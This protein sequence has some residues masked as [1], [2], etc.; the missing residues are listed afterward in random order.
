M[1]LPKTICMLPWISIETSPIGTT[2]PCCLAI[3]EIVDDQGNKFD[4][5][6][7]DL[8]TI[9]N[10]SYMQR[11]RKQ[12][13]QGEKP[14][15]CNRCWQEEDAGRVSKRIY[16]K[17]RLKELVDKVD[18]DN[19]I[20]KQLW[21]VD[22]KL[23]NICNLKCRICGSWS[24]SKWAQEEINYMT[25][26]TNKKDHLAYKFLQQGAWP[27]KTQTFWDNL[28]QLLPN[29]K[30]FEFTGG[31]PF[32]IQEH[33]DLLQYAVDQGYAKNIDIH[34]N[35][36]GTQW[37]DS[38]ELWSHF[39]R[40]E[41]AFSIDNIGERFE[42]ERYGARWNEVQE[43][44]SKFHQLRDRFPNKITTQVCMTIN[45]QNVYYLEDLCNWINTQTFNDHFFNMLHDPK[46]MCI[47]NLTPE[48]KT[49]VVNKLAAGNF[50]PKHKAEI[51]RIIK[52]IE[53]GSG[54]NGAKFRNKM[55][56]TDR[57]RKQNFAKT[58]AEIA[59]AMGYE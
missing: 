16:S 46:H 17:I 59:E 44:I 21:F 15:T 30:Y 10:S 38:H 57:Y 56:Q 12:F 27:R 51:L 42:Y 19:E 39:R 37:P 22:L 25:E 24:S 53:N 43:N 1:N 7:T 2:R 41:I 26:L 23:G 4:L 18:Y 36:N 55:K 50:G 45:I 54:S 5:N 6:K 40:V 31:E 11:L 49:I 9:Y 13:R 48:A 35:T 33:F 8:E 14:E 34:Y 58:H 20:P 47:D 29:I 32:M 28:R 3:D 52:F